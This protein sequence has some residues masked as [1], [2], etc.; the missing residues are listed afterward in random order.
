M[1]TPPLPYLLRP[2]QV[3]LGVGAVL[4]VSAAATVAAAYGGGPARVLLLALALA[5]AAGSLLADRG[6][7]RSSEEL[8]AASAAGIAICGGAVGGPALDDAALP[9][10]LLAALFLALHRAAP[11]T[12]TWPAVSWLAGQLGVLRAMDAVPPALL[13]ATAL[14]VAIVGLVVALGARPLVARLVLL[15]SAPWWVVGVLLGWHAA[16]A[17][18]GA[19]RWL[20]A[21]LMVGAAAGLLV[22]RL[23]EPLDVLLGPP[24][25]VPVAA[26]LV[27]GVAVT[28]AFSS[29]GVVGITLTGYA[30]VLTANTAAGLL[31][32][33][34]RGLLL[35]VALAAG[36][37]AALLCIAQ[38]V[39]DRQWLALAV[40]LLLTALP[41]VLVA[42]LR[43]EDRPVAAPTVVLC[44][45]GA[46][47]LALPDRLLGIE[48]AAG[49]LTGLFAV[50]V[51]IGSFLDRNSRRGAAG[52]AVACA[53]AA[54]ALLVVAGDRPLLA[55]HLAVHG[56][57]TLGWAV[58]ARPGQAET[59]PG[60]A[61]RIGSA[62]LVVAA[63]LAAG[64]AGLPALEWYSL[65]AAAGLLLAQSPRLGSG[66]SWPAWGPGLLVAA[67]PSTTLAVVVPDGDR[68]M[69]ALAAAAAAMVLGARTGTRAPLVIGTSTALLLVLG[70][71]ARTLP[72]PVAAALVVGTVLLAVGVLRERRPVAGFGVRLAD[73][74]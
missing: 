36:G 44:L 38:L 27:A 43:R 60:T 2:L 20:S 61:W 18:A 8:L 11:R 34:R 46:V 35:P 26:G 39:A 62:Q 28:G 42:A 51:G 31:A 55:V 29:L 4:V 71:T 15:T 9:A 30:G 48:T 5:A 10:F 63:W 47:L 70:F 40:L 53:T 64:A 37:A 3:L 12:A 59:S 25:G 22:A 68:A 69:W 33:W 19:Q 66:P 13:T 67:A 52:A 16:W 21:A 17:D 57:L 14:G 50:S 54:V 23:R 49:L 32:G 7:L 58:R 41:T 73:L 1:G 72:G 65:P 24:R 45:A 56:A 6:R 74:R